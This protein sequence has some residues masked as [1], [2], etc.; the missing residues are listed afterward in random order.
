MNKIDPK[1]LAQE[2]QKAKFKGIP[3]AEVVK[4]LQEQANAKSKEP[5]KENKKH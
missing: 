1:I 2:L 3:A 4:R 5:K